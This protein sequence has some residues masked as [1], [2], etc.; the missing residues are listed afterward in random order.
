MEKNMKLCLLFICCMA[1]ILGCIPACSPGSIPEETS[2]LSNDEGAVSQEASNPPSEFRL[3]CVEVKTT[4]GSAKS[5]YT[6]DENGLLIQTKQSNNGKVY[7]PESITYNAQ[8]NIS[9]KTICMPGSTVADTIETYFYTSENVLERYESKS[10]HT[11]HTFSYLYDDKGRIT[12]L[13]QTDE[14]GALLQEKEYEYLDEYGSCR[15][16]TDQSRVQ[17]TYYDANHNE[18][19]LYSGNTD[20]TVYMDVRN[21]YDAHNQ[22]LTSTDESGVTISYA[23]VY[24]QDRIVKAEAFVDETVQSVILYTYDTYGNLLEQKELNAAG[25][26]VSTTTYTWIAD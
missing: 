4:F 13:R 18:L 16:T 26:P 14:S 12:K 23:N 11:I 24:E 3:A 22:L 10:G 8:N 17:E 25:T 2:G 19:R 5:E 15:I 21:T 9:E 7:R 6:Y 1:V 20:G